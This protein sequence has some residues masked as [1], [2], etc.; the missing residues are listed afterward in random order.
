MI[1]NF[2]KKNT[3]PTT[4]VPVS[5]GGT[6]ITSWS[7]YNFLYSSGGTSPLGIKYLYYSTSAGS[8]AN[9]TDY[10][11]TFSDI[12]YGTPKING[13]KSYNSNSTY[14]APASA[15]SNLNICFSSSN[16]P[17][18]KWLPFADF[19]ECRQ[20]S[21]TKTSNVSNS[22]TAW[23]GAFAGVCCICLKFTLSSSHD[24]GSSFQVYAGAAPGQGSSRYLTGLQ[25]TS[26]DSGTPRGAI[27]YVNSSGGVY[28]V[29]R[30]TTSVNAGA[31]I[32]L[33]NIYKAY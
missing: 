27:F 32:Y 2:V 33:S 14:Y 15:G 28:M 16:S 29:V 30:R 31:W 11:N 3:N 6:G 18:T 17:Y 7:G 22:D 9:S 25:Y 20:Y 24:A 19:N 26:G 8:I 21:L 12:Y 23:C 10:I 4:P 1:G 5:Q 13:S